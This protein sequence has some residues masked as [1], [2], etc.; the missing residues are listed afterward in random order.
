MGWQHLYTPIY[1][2]FLSMEYMY[3][4]LAGLSLLRNEDAEARMARYKRAI[5]LGGSVATGASFE[6]MG[7]PFFP[8]DDEI[9]ASAKQVERY[10]FD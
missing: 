2:P 10:V 7:L 8:S 5:G 4:R 9:A 3:G 1:L 6:A